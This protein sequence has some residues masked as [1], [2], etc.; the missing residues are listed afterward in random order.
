MRVIR[1]AALIA[2]LAGPAHGQSKVPTTLEE[3]M[4]SRK[5]PDQIEKEEA[6]DKA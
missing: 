6:A 5:T 2:T 3:M 1:A 4:G